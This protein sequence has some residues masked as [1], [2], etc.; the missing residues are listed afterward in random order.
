M[1]TLLCCITVMLLVVVIILER[2]VRA[3]E[4]Y[5]PYYVQTIIPC[6]SLI[7]ASNRHTLFQIPSGS[8]GT[9]TVTLSCTCTSTDYTDVHITMHGASEESIIVCEDTHVMGF[10]LDEIV[11][12]TVNGGSCISLRLDLSNPGPRTFMSDIV[13]TLSIG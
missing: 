8:K 11:E 12:F 9:G 1:T 4:T 13:A 6:S 2:R 7:L 5:N 3:L 10:E